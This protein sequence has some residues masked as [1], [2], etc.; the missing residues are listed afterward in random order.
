GRDVNHISA[1]DKT[2]PT[3]FRG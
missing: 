2:I 3:G 1:P